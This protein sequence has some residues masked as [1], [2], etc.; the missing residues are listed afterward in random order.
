MSDPSAAPPPAIRIREQ[1]PFVV[2][3]DV[4]LW[5][6]RFVEGADGSAAWA[7]AMPV[8]PELKR[9]TYTLCRC[10]SSG[11]RPF[12]DGTHR[13]VGIDGG[14]PEAPSA[15]DRSPGP[16][17]P[18]ERPCVVVVDGGPLW[19]MGAAVALP[20]GTALERGDHLLCRCGRSTTMPYCDRRRCVLGGATPHGPG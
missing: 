20:D 19:V 5:R 4:P 9:D 12:C 8:T 13:R 3:P 1:G 15:A 6:S 10:G 14:S 17:V 2:R 18:G 7:D 11:N 16:A